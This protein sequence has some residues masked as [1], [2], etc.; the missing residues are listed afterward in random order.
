MKRSMRRAMIERPL[1]VDP[2]FFAAVR[3]PSDEEPMATGGRRD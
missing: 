1:A 3:V 2:E